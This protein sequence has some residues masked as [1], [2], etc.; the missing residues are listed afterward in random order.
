MKNSSQ[1][2]HLLSDASRAETNMTQAGGHK[3]E[4]S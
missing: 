3:Y 1:Q 2:S 4:E